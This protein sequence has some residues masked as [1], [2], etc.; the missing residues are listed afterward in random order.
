VDDEKEERYIKKQDLLQYL[1][2]PNFLCN[3]TCTLLNGYFGSR[4]IYNEKDELESYSKL[5][6]RT[7]ASFYAY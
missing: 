4:G 1:N 3:K 5:Y 6:F 7:F 2:V